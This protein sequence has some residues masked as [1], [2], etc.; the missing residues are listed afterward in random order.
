MWAAYMGR[1]GQPTATPGFQGRGLNVRVNRRGPING[2]ANR[3]MECDG[4]AVEARVRKDEVSMYGV[5]ASQDAE[6]RVR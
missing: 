2:G 1:P 4:G 3:R 6:G 5:P